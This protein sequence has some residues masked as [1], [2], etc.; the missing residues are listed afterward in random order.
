[1]RRFTIE[2]GMD[3]EVA[4]SHL[5]EY[6][7]IS[8]VML[9][10]IVITMPVVSDVL[11]ERPAEQLSYYAYTDIANG[12]STRIVD[13]YAMSLE[14][15]YSRV[16]IE[17][18]FDIPDSVAGR[19][20]YVDISGDST[21]QNVTVFRGDLKSIVSIAGIGSTRRAGGKTSGHGINKITYDYP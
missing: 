17:S 12:V 9:L 6:I 16:S 4:V 10:L 18:D 1:M 3:H 21:S 19:D 5:I 20:Y 14:V 11:I 7:V 8:G 13:I 15:G 2:Q